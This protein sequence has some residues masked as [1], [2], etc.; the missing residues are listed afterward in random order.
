MIAILIFIKS[1]QHKFLDGLLKAKEKYP[2][3]FILGV[4]SGNLLFFKNP[5]L[6]II[7]FPF[8]KRKLIKSA[9]FILTGTVVGFTSML[10]IDSSYNFNSTGLERYEKISGI[11]MEVTNNEY[12]AEAVIT[13]KLGI[14]ILVELPTY[15]VIN[16]WDKITLYGRYKEI[17]NRSDFDYISYL[18]SRGINRYF[19]A[20]QIVELE[21]TPFSFI[22]NIKERLFGIFKKYLYPPNSDLINGILLGKDSAMNKNMLEIFKNSGISHI[23]S[24]SGFNFSLIFSLL[25][26]VFIF[27]NRRINLIFSLSSCTFYFFLVGVHNL[28]ALRAMLMLSVFSVALFFGRKISKL[29]IFSVVVFLF[30]ILFP[31]ALINVSFL[32]SIGAT[33]SIAAFTSSNEI[34][35]NLWDSL[36]SIIVTTSAINVFTL[37]LTY[38]VFGEFSVL[39]ILTNIVVLPLLPFITV[40]SLISILADFIGF[41]LVNNII[42]FWINLLVKLVI[43]VAE[44]V[45][46]L[47]FSKSK[48]IV[49]LIIIIFI[50]LLV[51][52]LNRNEAKKNLIKFKTS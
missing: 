15:P 6:L 7:F 25:N 41:D 45:S 16:N 27:T 26:S 18:K 46:D 52:A 42:F 1:L 31:Y 17:I 35:S 38:K 12:A 50:S 29:D 44:I 40:A 20:E 23:I 2:T 30:L 36:K 11:V 8:L 32:L 14:N 33:I 39:G 48:S 34:Q 9:I 47:E 37:P 4:V 24:V 43:K 5:L 10:L 13:Y 28:P 21:K 49:I 51:L 3:L 22:S 19:K